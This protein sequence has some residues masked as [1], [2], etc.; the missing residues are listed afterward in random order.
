MDHWFNLSMSETHSFFHKLQNI[1]TSLMHS[2][3]G[4][5]VVNIS[6]NYVYLCIQKK[7]QRFKLASLFSHHEIVLV[8]FS[9][10]FHLKRQS[11]LLAHK[12]CISSKRLEKNSVLNYHIFFMLFT[13]SCL[14]LFYELIDCSK[15]NDLNSH[16]NISLPLHPECIIIICTERLKKS[17]VPLTL[18]FI[19]PQGLKEI[20]GIQNYWREALFCLFFNADF[21]IFTDNPF[22]F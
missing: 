20:T 13:F 12:L 14:L 15:S 16:T 1:A 7:N 8:F 6:N 3:N 21:S 18:W 9:K 4:K 10:P 5:C 17:L 22:Y 11:L 2:K 19:M